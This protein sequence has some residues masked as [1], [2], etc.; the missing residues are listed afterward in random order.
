MLFCQR[1]KAQ[2]V[3]VFCQKILFAAKRRRK[4]FCQKPEGLDLDGQAERANFATFFEFLKSQNN[5]SLINKKSE[6]FEN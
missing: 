2:E 1:R 5:Q 3:K 4:I 6:F